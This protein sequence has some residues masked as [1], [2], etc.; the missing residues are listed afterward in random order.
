[1]LDIDDFAVGLS[2]NPVR[3]ALAITVSGE[4][5]IASA[6]ISDATG[7]LVRELPGLRAG[8]DVHVGDLTPGVYQLSLTTVDGEASVLRFVKR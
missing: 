4:R 1:M 7:R 2:P 8:D 6:R 3:D 5:D